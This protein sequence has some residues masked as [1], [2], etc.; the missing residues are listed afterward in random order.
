MTRRPGSSAAD[1]LLGWACSACGPAG[2]GPRCPRS[3]ISIGIATMVVVTGIPAS[4]QAA[5]M[6]ELAALGT[7]LLQ[8]AARS[9]DRRHAGPAAGGRGRRWSARIGPVTGVSAVANTHAVVRRSDR[10][11]PAGRLR[12]TVLAS[13][14]DLA[15]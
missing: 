1:V 5:L 14:L 6:R 10:L 2:C 12:L 15:R 3:G 8:A 4:S 13:R 9:P 11:D 7:N